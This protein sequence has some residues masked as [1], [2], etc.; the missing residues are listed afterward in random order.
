MEVTTI[1]RAVWVAGLLA[2]APAAH[3][4]SVD[5][6]GGTSLDYLLS[7]TYSAAVR[8]EERSQRLV[9]GANADDGNR[10]FD[11]G[12]LIN[13]RA[14]VL[15]E[16]DLQRGRYGVF[17]RGSAFY[18]DVYARGDNDHDSPATVNKR[19]DHDEFTDSAESRLGRR[20]RMLDAFVYGGWSL[21][22]TELDVRVG[23]QVVSWGESLFFPNMSGA[24]GPVDATKSNVPGT[25]VKD[26]LLPTSQAVARWTLTP[27]WTLSGYYQWDW[28]QTELNPAGAYFST[29]DVTGPG[30]RFLIAN[31]PVPPSPVPRVDV[32]RAADVE[33]DSEDQ[34]GFSSAY[35]FGLGTEV[36]LHHIRYHDKNPTGVIF[37]DPGF[38]DLLA[39]Q[40]RYRI[41]YQD[42]IRMTALSLSSDIRGTAVGAEVS[43]RENAGINVQAPGLAGG[44]GPTPTDA[45]VWQANLNATKILLP[46]RFWDQL[47]ILGELGWIR[48]DE[49]EPVREGGVA[50]DEISYGREAAAFQGVA[51]FTYR[52]VFP[53]WNLILSLAHANQ[54]N[55]RSPVAGALGSL[56]GQGDK[57]YAVGAT[58]KYLQN[59]ELQ[60]AYNHFGGE[61][62]ADDRPLADRSFASFSAKYGF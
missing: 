49:V 13:N 44:M 31:L 43:Y 37:E 19:G 18:D 29:S 39:G 57:R 41:F 26:I 47:T 58:F 38:A 62:D 53:G 50:Y 61:P 17:L 25:E 2:A 9:A 27:R 12:S 36:G 48:V 22:G 56:Y 54:F 3:A 24:Q 6:G 11:D 35:Q 5:L 8:T 1:A 45:D 7:F 40:S 59:L 46:T 55:D 42:D 52:Q 4:G 60:V 30:A 21:G 34:W 16:L 20:A 32:P 28:E 15:G 33:P 23:D 14:A 51:Q 10:N